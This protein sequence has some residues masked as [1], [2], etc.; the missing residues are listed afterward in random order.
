[1][2]DDDDGRL[3]NLKPLDRKVEIK[4]SNIESDSEI[5]TNFTIKIL[6]P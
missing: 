3:L 4:V 6:N 1:M 5:M 2:R